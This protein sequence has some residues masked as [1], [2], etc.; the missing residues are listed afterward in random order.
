MSWSAMEGKIIRYDTF[1]QQP[2]KLKSFHNLY[3][4]PILPII[5]SITPPPFAD[6]RNMS[7]ERL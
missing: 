6:V 5:W 3:V 2:R 4:K 1:V 7:F